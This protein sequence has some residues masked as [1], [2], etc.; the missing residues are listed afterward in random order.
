MIASRARRRDLGFTLVEL[1]VV[2]G[3]IALLISILLPALG[4]VRES[5]ALTKC[6]ANVRQ[7][8]QAAILYAND[9]K[10]VLLPVYSAEPPLH[11]EAAGVLYWPHLLVRGRYL[12]EPQRKPALPPPPDA[13]PYDYN[14]VFMCPQV[15]DIQQNVWTVTSFPDINGRDGVQRFTH[16]TGPLVTDNRYIDC[17]YALNGSD[18][19]LADPQT[20]VPNNAV[21][22]NRRPPF[23]I[24]DARKASALVM[25][26]DGSAYN[27]FNNPFRMSS[28]RHGGKQFKPTDPWRTGKVNVGFHDGH[29]E[30]LDRREMP[31]RWQ[32]IGA[33]GYTWPKFYVD[34]P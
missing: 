13:P 26:V 16:R 5:A 28:A 23:K 14:S 24:T 11:S 30:T 22:E 12:P 6:S 4:R 34:Q 15:P 29:V 31:Y 33:E 2:I 8:A 27:I 25:I 17:S 1:L 21:G 18:N 32:D 3:I 20:R 7:I 9:H 10:G 19:R